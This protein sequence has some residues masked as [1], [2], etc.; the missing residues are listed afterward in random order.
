MGR[1]IRFDDLPDWMFEVEETSMGT[2]VVRGF[3]SDVL[4]IERQGHDVDALLSR[5]RSEV[6]LGSGRG[7]ATG[8]SKPDPR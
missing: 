2:Y 5:C 1:A 8:S 7:E 3:C 4:R 6:E